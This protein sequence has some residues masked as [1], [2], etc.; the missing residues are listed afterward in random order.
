MARKSWE[1]VPRLNALL[2]TSAEGTIRDLLDVF[3]ELS[4]LACVVGGGGSAKFE[5]E[6]DEDET[7]EDDGPCVLGA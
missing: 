6:D 1:A 3:P 7:L 2:S 5:D 4:L